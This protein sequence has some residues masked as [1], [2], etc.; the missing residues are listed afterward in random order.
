M[1]GLRLT[2]V[3]SS[4]NSCFNVWPSIEELKELTQNQTAGLEALRLLAGSL[5]GSGQVCVQVQLFRYALLTIVTGC[6]TQ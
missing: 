3:R 5:I 4:E 1:N 2:Q 6:R